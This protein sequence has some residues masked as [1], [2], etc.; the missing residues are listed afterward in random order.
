MVYCIYG[1]VAG[2]SVEGV[3]ITHTGHAHC[4]DPLG[5]LHPRN[6]ELRWF[7]LTSACPTCTSGHT[8]HR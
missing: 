8:S 1:I 3:A 2:I 6:K 4:N 5:H 7:L